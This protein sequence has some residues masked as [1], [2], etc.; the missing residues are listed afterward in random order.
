MAGRP[1]GII[2]VCCSDIA[3]QVRGKGFPACDLDKRR[4]FGVGWTPTNVMINCFGRIP[5]TP[6][7]A[8]GDLML[9]PQPGGDI[10]LDAGDGVPP[11]H[12]ILGDI[13][14]MAGEPWEC[15]L[16]GVLK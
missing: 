11:E 10:V 12:I 16:R 3:G 2:T 6:F 8:E 15:C 5:A 1:E 4:R 9:V 7:G 14:T 13:R